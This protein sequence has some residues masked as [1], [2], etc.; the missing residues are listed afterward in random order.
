[1][2]LLEPGHTA[3]DLHF[4]VFG[5]P[6]RVHPVF[7]LFSAIM[8]FGFLHAGIPAFLVWMACVFFSLL[9]H[10]LGHVFMFRVCGAHAH[11][12]LYAFGGLA[13][14]DRRL[15]NRWQRIAVSFAGPLAEFLI[16]AV[17]AVALAIKN[18]D[19]L[20]AIA[21]LGLGIFGIRSHF[22]GFL[23]MP[24]LMAEAVFILV[25]IN[26]FWALLNLLPIYPLDG[27]QISR[28][29]LDGLIP[30]GR[31]IRMS[32]GIS[33][34]LA[35]LLTVHCV[36]SA[37]GKPLIPFLPS[38]GGMYMAI[39]FGMLALQ[40]FQMLQQEGNPPWRREG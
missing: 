5:T 7:W 17:L 39:L 3:F 2:L 40:S 19:D 13:I 29:F 11:V 32:L 21:D 9:V 30:H 16:I 26:L 28:D 12:V 35:G 31:G 22:G 8:G 1:M 10:E 25:Y 14:P 24:P 6:V 18:V 20:K 38:I 27:G 15:H 37:N 23:D 33:L 36:A 4:R 34:V